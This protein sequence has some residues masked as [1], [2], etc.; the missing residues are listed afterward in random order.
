MIN[1]PVSATCLME[2][3]GAP[4]YR[5]VRPVFTARSISRITVLSTMLMLNS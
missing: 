3:L 1:Q 5:G 2:S 4:P